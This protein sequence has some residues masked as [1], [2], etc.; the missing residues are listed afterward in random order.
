MGEHHDYV[1]NVS[2]YSDN[3]QSLAL[4]DSNF[5][6]TVTYKDTKV[7]IY[8]C[9]EIVEFS[10]ELILKTE[11]SINSLNYSLIENFIEQW[12]LEERL[13]LQN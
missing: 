6:L 12:L 13:T 2:D 11:I 10:H 8:E 7:F 5:T 3:I 4:K 1:Q 9:P